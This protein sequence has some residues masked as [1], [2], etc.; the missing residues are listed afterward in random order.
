MLIE[1]RCDKFKR[2]PIT[3]HEG[4]NVVLGDENATNSIGKSTLLM[5][6]DFAFGG[7]TLVDHN[8]DLTRE[9]GDHDYFFTFQFDHELHRFRRGTEDPDVVAVC[10]EGFEPISPLTLTEYN[11]FLRAAYGISLPEI[12]F[13]AFVGLYLR[14][15]GK[16]NLDVYRP[17]HQAPSQPSRD[18]VNN[19]IK[20]YGRYEVIKALTDTLAVTERE[21]TAISAAYREQIIPR[22]TKSEYRDNEHRI[23]QVQ[24]EL[25]DIKHQLAQY[26]TNLSSIINKEMLELKV[27]KD[28]LL[29]SKLHLQTQLARVERNIANNRHVQSKH[30]AS[31][32]NFFPDIN[33][34]R[35]VGVEE[36]HNGLARILKA[37]LKDA[38]EHLSV[39]IASIEAEITS[40]DSRM[41]ETLASVDRPTHIVDRVYELANDLRSAKGENQ[42][43]EREAALRTEIDDIESKLSSRKRQILAEIQ[44]QING[45]LRSV[46][47]S[48][49]GENRKSPELHLT[50]TNY[51]YDIFEDTGTGTAYANLI[52]LDLTI[53]MQTT[54]PVIAH[55]SL[56]F[57][58]IENDSVANLFNI[59]RAIKKQSFAAIDEIEKY[60][61]QAAA[62]LRSSA[63]IELSDADVLYVKDWRTSDPR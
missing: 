49:F 4:L 7:S 22:I 23:S 57:K 54:L 9:L 40:I 37:E 21:R 48:V 6:I 53:F 11:S 3:F 50:E 44:A 47:S 32:L 17:L 45:G 29:A 39:Q 30:F 20:S 1:V 14:V 51:S 2:G 60:G 35:L 28:D 34:E 59:Y 13:R 62:A 5:V 58:N 56:L 24:S 55:D 19:L 12:S 26:A 31:V 16:E 8:K 46:V 52:V 38:R 33:Q 25:D 43:F 36:F 15:W 41:A 10:D 42:H 27:S 18:C 61:E 63:V